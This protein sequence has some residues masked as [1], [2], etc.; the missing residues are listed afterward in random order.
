V[1]PPAQSGGPLRAAADS[2]R[3]DVLAR[4][5]RRDS[6]RRGRGTP[7]SALRIALVLATAVALGAAWWALDAILRIPSFDSVRERS[8]SSEAVLLDRHGVVIHERRVDP[9]RRCLG[10]TAL[11]DVSPAVVRALLA[12][13]D[14]RF[15]SHP[16]VDPRSVAAAALEALRGNRP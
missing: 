6:E 15:Y 4:T 10:W 12:A 2:G 9:T 8:T 7:M 1:H 16:G 13:E 3:S 11:G 5:L 14:R